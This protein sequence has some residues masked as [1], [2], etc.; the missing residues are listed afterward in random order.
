MVTGG[1]EMFCGEL[2][3]PVTSDGTGVMSEAVQG[4]ESKGGNGDELEDG[5]IWIHY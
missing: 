2:W 3:A 1:R 4:T 5:D